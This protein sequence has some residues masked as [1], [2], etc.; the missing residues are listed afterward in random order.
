MEKIMEFK[1]QAHIVPHMDTG[2]FFVLEGTVNIYHSKIS[3]DDKA[4][5]SRTFLFQMLEGELFLPLTPYVRSDGETAG[6]LAIPEND[7]RINKATLKLSNAMRPFIEEF[8]EKT[9]RRLGYSREKIESICEGLDEPGIDAYLNDTMHQIDDFIMEELKKAEAANRRRYAGESE[10]FNT[11]MD[12][13]QSVI[14]G[15]E[16]SEPVSYG[17]LEHPLVRVCAVVAREN[18]IELTIPAAI[19]NGDFSGDIIKN[20]ALASNF[21]T[22][23][24]I[25]TENWHKQDGGNFVA[26][27]TKGGEPVALL[28][29][30]TKSYILY[31]PQIKERI[32]VTDEIAEII[33]PKAV[34]FYR[35]LPARS[36]S[37]KDI[38]RFVFKGTGS[39]DWIWIFILG[40]CGGLLGMLSPIISGAI[41]ETVIPA[42]DRTML[43]QIGF[44]MA[45]MAMT[46]FAFGLTRAFAVQRISGV[47]ERDLQSAVWDRL[48]SLPISFFNKISAG[49]LTMRAML[50][51]QIR[52]VLSGVVVNTIITSI[53]SVFYIIV[54]FMRSPRLAWIGLAIWVVI[55]VVSF[56]FGYMQLKYERRL[57]KVNNKLSGKMFGWLSGLSKIKMA[58]AEKRTFYNWAS[59]FKRSR[60]ITFRNETIGI[61]SNVWGTSVGVLASIIIYAAMFGLRD[62][63]LTIG[64]FIAFNAALGS[65]L[66]ASTDLSGAIL[67]VNVVGPLYEESKV[68]FETVPESDRMKTEAPHLT[69]DIELSRVSFKYIKDGPQVIRDISLRIR[70]G[71][72]V[73]IVGPSGGG[74]S[75]LLRLLLAF[76]LPDSGEIFYD[77]HNLDQLDIRSVRR[78]LGVVLQSG[79]LFSGS[80]YE[81][82]AG[83]NPLVTHNDVMRAIEQ[84]GMEDDLKRMPMGLHTVVSE[85]S[86][87]I[88]GG[89]RQRLLIARALVGSPKIL[90]FDEATSALD[91]KTQKIVLDTVNSLKI[92]RITVAH[93]LSTIEECDRIIVI[94]GGV[95]TEEGT[96]KKLM[97]KGGTFAEMAKRQMA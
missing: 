84:A 71:E 82:I 38:I 42:G 69:G 66:Q 73:A 10:F 45:A 87:T 46:Q 96:F 67:T 20:I 7:V 81:N 60:E 57:L 53:F 72:H 74:K 18:K 86:D 95:I 94:E 64:A 22:R 30:S 62:A 89:Q 63:E 23:E 17:G 19:R 70:S 52:E 24:V 31:N 4:F 35:S 77:G 44:L 49:E 47:T 25:L 21:R 13:L 6:L 93:R 39:S 40:L 2:A 1:T 29:K 33:D 28:R 55:L 37:G 59:I 61:W 79:Q 8:V 78:Q 48:L 85:G 14:P 41:F 76:E 92:T 15:E 88:S 65:L 11:A 75:T 54:M 5:G 68:I 34:M 58:G 51:S 91:N 12:T 32:N 3:E 90:F 9:G 27:H 36:L 26:K 50:V 97:E 83:A 43:V 56:V 80:I 16:P